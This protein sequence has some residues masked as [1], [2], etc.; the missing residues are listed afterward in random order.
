MPLNLLA[1]S[2]GNTRAHFG[3]FVDDEL[4]DTAAAEV[5]KGEAELERLAG[6]IAGRPNAMCLVGSVHPAAAQRIASLAERHFPDTVYHVEKDVPI[7]IG[8]Q[9]DPEAI[10]GDDRLLNAAAAYDVTKQACAIVDAGTAVTVDFVDGAGTYH[11]GAILPGMAMMLQSLA[12]GG[13]QLPEVAWD[14][15]QEAIGHNTQ[16]AVRSG[17]F[18]GLRGAVREL[19]ETFAES[20]SGYPLVV[21]TGGDAETLFDDYPLV[22]RIVPDLTLQG[23]AVTA[24]SAKSAAES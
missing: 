23:I 13:A 17:I 2:I 12:R 14:R 19:V 24:R 5:D 18:H 6:K 22:E 11:G 4:D 8:R 15:P 3:A 16:E 21:A 10:V 9:L 1:I 7:A 20:T